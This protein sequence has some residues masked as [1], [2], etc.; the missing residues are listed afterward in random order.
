M[1]T[2]DFLPDGGGGAGDGF[3]ELVR[4]LRLVAFDFDGVFTDNAVYV[5]E[6]GRELVRCSRGDGLGIGLL[7]GLGLGLVIVS[8]E[9]NPVVS[10]RARKLA[11]EC[12]QGCSDKLAALDQL[13]ERKGVE[14]GQTAFLGN[15]INDL[16]CLRAVGL[17]VAVAD[18]HPDILPHVRYR[19]RAP[20]G[21]GAVR[22]FCDSLHRVLT[23]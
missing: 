10:A 18:S 1:R 4:S 7:K 14:R 8:T 2:P 12:V 17:P 20:G 5:Q 9:T 11:L 13:L 21:H 6:D 22:E 16:A 23:S 3:R 19:T 15:D